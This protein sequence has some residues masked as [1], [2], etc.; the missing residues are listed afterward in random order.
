EPIG[1]VLHVPIDFMPVQFVVVSFRGID[2]TGESRTDQRSED[3]AIPR[4]GAGDA[5]SR[6]VG[7]AD[8][9]DEVVPVEKVAGSERHFKNGIV[10]AEKA[11]HVELHARSGNRAIGERYNA[12]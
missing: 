10:F 1:R 2:V 12:S 8:G 7:S 6:A 3:A 4:G 5:R 11:V 9:V